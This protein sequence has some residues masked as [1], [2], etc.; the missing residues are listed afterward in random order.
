[1]DEE[2][3]KV[4]FNLVNNNKLNEDVWG[5]YLIFVTDPTDISVEKKFV[6]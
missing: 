5:P 3:K 4:S 1:M 6:K 2:C